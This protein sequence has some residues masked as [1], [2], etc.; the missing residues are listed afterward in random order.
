MSS[1]LWRREK[2]RS[3]LP[4]QMFYVAFYLQA[5]TDRTAFDF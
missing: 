2:R 1:L 3:P 5:K 4:G